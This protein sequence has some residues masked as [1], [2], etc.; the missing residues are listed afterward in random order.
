V[1]SGVCALMIPGP[2]FIFQLVT[3]PTMATQP[4]LGVFL[5]SGH[6]ASAGKSPLWFGY[7]F[8]SPLQGSPLCGFVIHF[9]RLC[10]EVPFVVLLFIPLAS[11]GKSPLWFCHLFLSPLQGSPLVAFVYYSFQ[12]CRE[13]TFQTNHEHKPLP[14]RTK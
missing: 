14:A 8:L 1:R 2:F 13:V 5:L 4:C 3:L 12:L 7:S 11:A 9:S 10:R 6:L